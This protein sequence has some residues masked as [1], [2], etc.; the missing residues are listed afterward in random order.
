MFR[1]LFKLQA[2]IQKGVFDTQLA[3]EMQPEDGLK[4]S[5]NM[6]LN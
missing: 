6:S 3:F 1:L 5:R 2:A 4:R